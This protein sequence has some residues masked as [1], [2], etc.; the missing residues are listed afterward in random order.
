MAVIILQHNLGVTNN[1]CGHTDYP[2]RSLKFFLQ[3]LRST[4]HFGGVR[5]AGDGVWLSRKILKSYMLAGWW[6]L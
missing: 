5:G 4:A 1:K 2:D 6:V 3:G